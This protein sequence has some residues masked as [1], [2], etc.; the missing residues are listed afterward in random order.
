MNMVLAVKIRDHIENVHG[1]FKTA[2]VMG[3]LVAA[4]LLYFHL[5]PITIARIQNNILVIGCSF[6]GIVFYEIALII[7]FIRTKN[8]IVTRFAIAIA[9]EARM[10]AEHKI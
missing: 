1:W 6:V 7:L 5:A 8:R 10:K 4:A 3:A 9:L 2:G